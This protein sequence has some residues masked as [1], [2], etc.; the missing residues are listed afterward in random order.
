MIWKL[1][2]E[3]YY[4]ILKT[5]F[6][7]IFFCIYFNYFVSQRAYIK[8]VGG[9]NTNDAVKKTLYKLFSNKLAEKYNWEGRCGKESLRHLTLIKVIFSK[10]YVAICKRNNFCEQLRNIYKYIY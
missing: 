1:L 5:K 10:Y 8:S 7:V 6:I 3:I 2:R 9:I 4:Y